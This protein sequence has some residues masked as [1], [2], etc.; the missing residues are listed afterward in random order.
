MLK[1]HFFAIIEHHNIA[2][3]ACQ[4]SV[5]IDNSH[6]AHVPINVQYTGIA[7]IESND[8]AFR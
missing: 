5:L 2:E 3:D 1:S 6:L 4:R 7:A 8:F